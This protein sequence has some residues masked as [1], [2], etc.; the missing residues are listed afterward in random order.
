[1][2][3]F[4]DEFFR[5]GSPAHDALMIKCLSKGGIEKICSQLNVLGEWEDSLKKTEV[6]IVICELNDGR[7][8][9][10]NGSVES[11][12]KQVPYSSEIYCTKAYSTYD[13][14]RCPNA[15]VCIFR[16]DETKM[17]TGRTILPRL[18]FN[19]EITKETEV[20][21][22][23]GNFIIGYAD[24]VIDVKCVASLSLKITDTWKW[25][26][27]TTRDKHIKI[28]IEAKPKLSSIGEVIRQLKT[29][30]DCINRSGMVK[31]DT[32]LVIATYSKLGEDSLEYL[33]NEGISVVVFEEPK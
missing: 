6:D 29:Y 31:W 1:M 20:L 10:R 7:Q 27:A 23:S 32:R 19:T 21:M 4:H 12:I 17:P 3:R 2:S 25:E 5:Q 16:K 9:A 30:S 13:R 15:D 28:L 11:L 24:A 22:K 8:S 18:T 26:N 33:A 14:E